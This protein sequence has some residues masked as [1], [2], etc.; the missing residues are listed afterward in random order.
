MSGLLYWLIL[1]VNVKIQDLFSGDVEIC[2]NIFVIIFN[3]H[4]LFH[5]KFLYLTCYEFLL[6]LYCM[7]CD[8]VRRVWHVCSP[9]TS[10][11]FSLS[12][13][14]PFLNSSREVCKSIVALPWQPSVTWH[15]QDT[16]VTFTVFYERPWA[17]T[18]SL[19]LGNGN[20]PS[21]LPNGCCHRNTRVCHVCV[22]CLSRV[23]CHGNPTTS[24]ARRDGRFKREK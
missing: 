2:W 17:D 12:N 13:T 8:S 20:E 19:E 16:H 21:R 6:D 11:S 24:A 10:T 7:K 1:D 22:K 3:C 15:P 18:P 9:F 14:C 5:L 4:W 23:C